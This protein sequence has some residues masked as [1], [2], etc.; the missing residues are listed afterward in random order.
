MPDDRAI[1]PR[2]FR[3]RKYRE[4]DSSAP[5]DPGIL[6][7]RD[8]YLSTN[9]DVATTHAD[10]LHHF[11]VCGAAE[12]RDPHP[13]FDSDW[14][15]AK[16]ADVANAGHNPLQH[17]L[18]HGFQEGRD[19]HPLFDSDWYLA[20]NPDV[21]RSGD[22][23]LRHYLTHGF[24]EG[25]DPHP[26][27]DSDWYLAEN[28]DISGSGDNPLRHYVTHGFREGRDPHPLFH[29]EYYLQQKNELD[30]QNVNPLVHYLNDRSAAFNPNSKFHSQ[31]YLEQNPDVAA[32]RYNPL[33]HFVLYGAKENRSPHPDFDLLRYAQSHPEI[34][35]S[36]INPLVHFLQ[37]QNLAGGQ[38]NLFL[39][40]LLPRPEAPTSA[41]FEVVPARANVVGAKVDIIIPVYAGY[42]D[43]LACIYSVLKNPQRTPYE[44]VIINDCSPDAALSAALLDLSRRGLFTYL[45]NDENL[46]FIRTVN[47]GAALHP[48][49]DVVLLN[50]DTVVYGDWL[51]RMLAHA[52][53]DPTIAT[54]T[55]LSNNATVCS[56]PETN[57]VNRHLLEVPPEQIDQYAAAC[58]AGS[59]NTVPTGV[60][61][62]F[63]MRRETIARI[64]GFDAGTFGRGYGEENDF[65]M[66]AAKAGYRN[67]F[68][69]DIFVYH[70]GGLSFSEASKAACDAAQIKLHAKH[71]DYHRRVQDYIRLDPSRAARIR[72]DAYRV[73]QAI[74]KRSVVIVTHEFGGGTERH[75]GELIERLMEY[76]QR[77]VTFRV[78]GPN[79]RRIRLQLEN[80]PEGLHLPNLGEMDAVNDETSFKEVLRLFDPEFIHV[81]S[82]VGFDRDASA[83]AMRAIQGSEVPYVYTW[84]DFAPICHRNHLVTPSRVYCGGSNINTCRLCL[85]SD[86]K[87]SNEPDPAERHATYK[88][89][90]TGASYNIVPSRS[91]QDRVGSFIPE[92]RLRLKSHFENAE[93]ENW[94]PPPAHVLPRTIAVVGAIGAHKGADVLHALL[95]DVNK[96][97]LPLYYVLVGHAD[98]DYAKFRQ[99]S[100]TG[101]Y[102]DDADALRLLSRIQPD[103]C[104]FPSIWPE[105]YCYAVSL[106]FR[107]GVPPVVFDLGAQAE[108]VRQAGWGLILPTSEIEHPSAVNDRFLGLELKSLWDARKRLTWKTLGDPLQEYYEANVAIAP[109]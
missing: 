91:A 103:L 63:Y 80:S 37:S 87:A 70:T 15:L 73:V 68:A 93:P 59:S 23:P 64:G 14:Y 101:K 17:Y 107:I 19:P 43:T 6:F 82:L 48:D 51:D 53:R 8:Y 96:R 1:L 102:A 100:T 26:L 92:A 56:Y 84:H 98:R 28:P 99:F 31:W 104:F 9:P 55:P 71:P 78:G 88:E 24:R 97:D 42:E 62:C 52:A 35:E 109:R 20:E 69:H 67:I 76:G 45:I 77:V 39:R 47:R 32:A 95:E 75:V 3:V 7:D 58:N 57:R 4:R 74:G 11:M 46:G 60:G 90:L 13:L 85:D 108:R 27:F 105:T 83:S 34:R 44:L 72:L 21:A 65:C 2:L 41:A 5:F 40:K 89:F 36:G 10:P 81:H 50:S 61:F 30:R 66:R 38:H 18:T 12:G 86:S 33:V 25:R 29:S 79:K 22:N 16:N 54:I 94:L 106:A 49:R